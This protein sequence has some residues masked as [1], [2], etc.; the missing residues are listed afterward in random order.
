MWSQ[1]VK[2]GL[3][4]IVGFVVDSG[5]LYIGLYFLDL[6]LYTGRILSYLVAAST[7][8]ALNRT[9]TFSSPTRKGVGKEWSLFLLVN[10]FGG[11]VNYGAY[12][13]L[14]SAIV[15]FAHFPV[16]AVAL[17]SIAGLVFNF[18][19]S[20]RFVFN[21]NKSS[22][23]LS[24]KDDLLIQKNSFERESNIPGAVLMLAVTGAAALVG[25]VGLVITA[26]LAVNGWLVLKLV[27]GILVSGLA[28]GI[29]VVIRHNQWPSLF[30]YAAGLM[31]V[32]WVAIETPARHWDDFMTWLP[33]TEYIRVFQSLP[34][35][36]GPTT[37]SAFP[38]YPP[39]LP[40]LLASVSSVTGHFSS[41]LGGVINVIA[42]TVLGS[43]IM[44][45]GLGHR[46]RPKLS[47][48]VWSTALTLL[49]TL[50]NPGLAW[51][52]V[53]SSLPDVLTDIS[54]ACLAWLAVRFWVVGTTEDRAS[55]CPAAVFG[56]ILALLLLLRQTGLVLAIIL[57]ISILGVVVIRDGWREAK[58][59]PSHPSGLFLAFAPGLCVMLAWRIYVV[60]L[61]P[62]ANAFSVK[63]LELW[64]WRA[65]PHTF[66]AIGD[67]A[68]EHWG[69]TLVEVA[70][71]MYGIRYL[72]NRWKDKAEDCR[73]TEEA[74]VLA[75]VFAIFW[76]F[77]SGFL[78]F[79]YLAAFNFD[80]ALK[81][82]EF[83]RYQSHVVE[84]GLVVAGIIVIKIAN[85]PNVNA[86]E[87]LINLRLPILLSLALIANIFTR[88]ATTIEQPLFMR[89][90]AGCE[91]SFI[92]Q[93][94]IDAIWDGANA[95]RNELKAIPLG[96]IAFDYDDDYFKK[97]FVFFVTRFALWQS[98]PYRPLNW[99]EWADTKV[100][101][102][103]AS[104]HIQFPSKLTGC[105]IVISHKNKGFWTETARLQAPPVLL[106]QCLQKA[107]S[108]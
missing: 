44:Y 60:F 27:I 28:W 37:I 64:N 35:V 83:F 14:V 40:V 89:Y 84:F 2:F 33:A 23:E 41:F 71:A 81:A 47:F 25:T 56:F 49:V 31:P 80:E 74:G 85:R 93:N 107:V 51:H 69:L 15:F 73:E 45:S 43:L 20:R 21:S 86:Y 90:S 54:L 70:V 18:S 1:F 30:G 34:V 101:L 95:I 105:N 36:G 24:D 26:A 98:D 96:L 9:F 8:W 22:L 11:I 67:I 16:L 91:C 104:E 97:L 79:C 65:L 29:V 13:V 50:G 42:L 5:V 103:E 61:L 63:P 66:F 102:E 94:E 12:A 59:W 57:F 52:F 100:K 6:N 32:L 78:V 62:N 87:R 46:N 55:F 7:T 82:A 10:G 68:R 38:G 92:P 72:S 53:L 76:L 99:A 75:G 17:G 88:P 77:Y 4:G 19:L 48:F 108:N 3:V 106:T 58:P 39:G